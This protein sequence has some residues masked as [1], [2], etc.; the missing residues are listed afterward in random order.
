MNGL[1]A[2][3]LQPFC[4]TDPHPDFAI[5]D[6]LLRRGDPF[7]GSVV[8][9]G[10]DAVRGLLRWTQPSTDIG[11]FGPAG[12]YIRAPD[13]WQDAPRPIDYI[14]D[15]AECRARLIAY[16]IAN[17]EWARRH[18]VRIDTGLAAEQFR[19]SRSQL[20]SLREWRAA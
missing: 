8:V 18:L 2:D 20:D 13:G 10:Y 4:A 3:A 11:G 1:T 12:L 17:L 5:G 15:A 19:N 9:D 14:E 7:V 16:H 6:V